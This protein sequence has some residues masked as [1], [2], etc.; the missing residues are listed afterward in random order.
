MSKRKGRAGRPRN[1]NA[2][3]RQSP[4]QRIDRGT[5]ELQ[6]KRALAVGNVPSISDYVAGKEIIG[7]QGKRDPALSTHPLDIFF[8]KEQITEDQKTA[9]WR[10]ACL[11]FSQY[12][13]PAVSA[14]PLTDLVH[15]RLDAD[16]YIQ[17]QDIELQRRME[18]ESAEI[19]LK[20]AGEAA[21]DSVRRVC[22][23]GANEYSDQLIAGLNALVRHWR[24]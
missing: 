11:R 8:A 21:R 5:P 13:K 9:G 18:F 3:R 7:I 4:S 23:F 16:D 24:L 2:K 6:L 12:G 22:V 15:K 14:S 1:P 10:Y 20:D 19:A 17:D